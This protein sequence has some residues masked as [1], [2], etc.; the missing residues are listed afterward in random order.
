MIEV[1]EMMIED[2]AVGGHAQEALRYAFIIPQIATD[3]MLSSA[4]TETMTEIAIATVIGTI[5]AAEKG[6]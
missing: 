3:L 2:T 6:R 4:V 1:E 5:T